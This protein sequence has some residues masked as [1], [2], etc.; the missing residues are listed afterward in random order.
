MVKLIF[1]SIVAIMAIKITFRVSNFF[2]PPRDNW[3]K[4]KWEILMVRIGMAITVAALLFSAIVG[5]L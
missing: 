3:R 1:A 4:S 2:I 5:L